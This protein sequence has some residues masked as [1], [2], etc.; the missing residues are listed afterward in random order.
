MGMFLVRKRGRG[1]LLRLF[2]VVC[3]PPFHNLLS[4]PSG[5]EGSGLPKT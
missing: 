4:S 5:L 3:S 1:V 2:V